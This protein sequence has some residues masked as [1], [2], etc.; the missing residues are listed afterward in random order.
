M[1]HVS[2]HPAQYRKVSPGTRQSGYF[3]YVRLA[4]YT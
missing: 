2:I 3:Q 4:L 1:Q